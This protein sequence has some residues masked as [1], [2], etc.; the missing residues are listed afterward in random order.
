MKE[1]V[2]KALSEMIANVNTSRCLLALTSAGGVGHASTTVRRI[3][4]QQICSAVEISGP[5]FSRLPR[6]AIERTLTAVA[7]TLADADSGA[8]YVMHAWEEY[9]GWGG[10]CALVSPRAMSY[11]AFCSCLGCF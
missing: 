5:K 10:L 7:Q 4:I 9:R 6:D 3:T 1:D 11:G 8:R 2:E